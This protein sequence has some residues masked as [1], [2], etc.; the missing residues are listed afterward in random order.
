MQLKQLEL[1]V[2]AQQALRDER[3]AWVDLDRR[4]VVEGGHHVHIILK[5]W[6]QV[7]RALQAEDAFVRFGAGSGVIC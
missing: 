1:V 6:T 2:L 4:A 3:R 7:F 5:R